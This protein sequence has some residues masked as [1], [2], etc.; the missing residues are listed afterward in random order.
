MYP[1][2][3]SSYLFIDIETVA[4]CPTFESLNDGQQALWLRKARI[5]FGKK[6]VAEP[7]ELRQSYVEKAAIYAEYGKIV[8]IS[9]AY[10]SES[11]TGYVLKTRSLFGI[12]E[13]TLL[14]ELKS[15]FDQHFYN[16]SRIRLVGHNIRE[17]DI[18][19]ICRRM[20][21]Q[22]IALPR[23]LKL[24][25]KRPWE[26]KHIVDTL[27]LWRFGDYKNYSSLALLTHIFN[28]P[29][30]KDDIDGSQVHS[31]FYEDH[32]IVRIAKYCEK[33]VLA[34]AE[35]FLKLQEEVPSKPIEF[36]SVTEWTVDELN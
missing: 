4:Q 14:L 12:N 11:S 25:G 5:L 3:L 32:D 28:I 31:C 17:F 7:A 21:V 27:E 34:V 6:V 9:M 8:C 36:S 33:D 29:T 16:R 19:Y 23:I 30:P 26:I 1:I 20:K 15:I 22:N 2:P 35:L 13:Q 24:S 10:L 18:P